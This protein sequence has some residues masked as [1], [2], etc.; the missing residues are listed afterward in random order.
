MART[1]AV[2]VM[3]V[4]A[5]LV[6]TPTLRRRRT[7]IPPADRCRNGSSRPVRTDALEQGKTAVVIEPAAFSL[8][9]SFIPRVR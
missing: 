4:A 9:V 6:L 8:R 2:P 5:Q 7:A 3:S 1:V